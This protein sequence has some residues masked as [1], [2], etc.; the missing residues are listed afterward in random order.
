MASSDPGPRTDSVEASRLERLWS[1]TFGDAY[2]ERNTDVAG[3]RGPFWRD[4]VAET[5]PASVLEIGANVG[6]NLS[7]LTQLAPDASIT[8]LDVNAAAVEEMRRRV[9]PARGVVA[10]ARALPFASDAFDL[11]ATVAVLIH[12]PD[13]TLLTAMS[14][15][16]RCARRWLLC[17]E[18]HDATTTEVDWRGERGALFKR[19]Y[20][21]IYREHFPELRLV[22]HGLLDRSQ[23]WDDV[24]FWLF[25]TA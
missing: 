4:V 19:D 22:R 9:P 14:E 3:Y 5:R 23:G 25:A 20:G 18:L 15:V 6:A 13:D 1:G 21:A 24:T 17:A 2:T 11:V 16:V 10:G 8:G 12:Q 7:W